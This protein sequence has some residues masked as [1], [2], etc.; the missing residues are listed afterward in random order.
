MA[1]AALP[2]SSNR[3]LT[4]G[5]FTASVVVTRSFSRFSSEGP[6]AAEGRVQDLAEKHRTHLNNCWHRG[7]GDATKR[8]MCVWGYLAV[9][10]VATS[11]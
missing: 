9:D 1:P 2:L 7:L 6:A 8:A 4:F 3:V 5:L 11:V 10:A